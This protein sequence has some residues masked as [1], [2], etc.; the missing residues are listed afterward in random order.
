MSCQKS[1]N[2]VSRWSASRAAIS[3]TG[4]QAAN[5]A[6]NVLDRVATLADKVT[7]QVGQTQAGVTTPILR[8]IDRPTTLAAKAAPAVA[9]L[10]GL[11]TARV[12]F[13]TRGPQPVLA[14]GVTWRDQPALDPEQRLKRAA[15]RVALS[16]GGAV[17]ATVVAH[18]GMTGQPKQFQDSR[19]GKKVRIGPAKPRLVKAMTYGD[20]L[21]TGRNVIDQRGKIVRGDQG[22]YFA[23]TTT[24][25]TSAGKQTITHVRKMGLPA[26]SYYF[27]R[28]LKNGE[29]AALAAGQSQAHKMKGYAGTVSAEE[30]LVPLWSAQKRGMIL[31]ALHWPNRGMA[32]PPG[33]TWQEQKA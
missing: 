17:G 22:N 11:V 16:A 28:A 32:P 33:S 26:E 14:V 31:T 24:V 12:A 7:N 19:T 13:N 18:Q 25:K 3:A 8:A 27:N 21:V 20:R 5:M 9:M 10:A 2:N 4:S 15:G 29:L 1:A 23:G 6:G 30:N